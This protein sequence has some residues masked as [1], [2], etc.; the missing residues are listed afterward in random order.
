[1]FAL[2]HPNEQAILNVEHAL[3]IITASITMRDHV[4]LAIV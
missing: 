1:M 4:T 3:E 2:L